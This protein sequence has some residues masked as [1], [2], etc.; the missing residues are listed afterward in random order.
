M[1]GGSPILLPGLDH[2]AATFVVVFVEIVEESQQ[3]FARKSC[4]SARC[5]S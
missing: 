3:K 2:V 1:H 5:L 4:S